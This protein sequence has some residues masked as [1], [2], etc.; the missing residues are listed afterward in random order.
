MIREEYLLSPT[1]SDSLLP[2]FGLVTGIEE[3][4]I[5]FERTLFDDWT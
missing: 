4:K 3:T 2:D 1:E 5:T